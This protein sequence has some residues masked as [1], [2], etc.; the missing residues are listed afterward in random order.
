VSRRWKDCCPT[1][2][3]AGSPEPRRRR[4]PPNRLPCPR[5]VP[6]CRAWGELV[7]AVPPRSAASDRWRAQNSA[8]GPSS[9]PHP[10]AARWG[11]GKGACN[12]LIGHGPTM[13]AIR[14]IIGGSR[15]IYGLYL[16]SLRS[17]TAR[18]VARA[19]LRMAWHRPGLAWP[20][21]TSHDTVLSDAREDHAQRRSAQGR[22]A[23]ARIRTYSAQACRC[24]S[25]TLVRLGYGSHLVFRV[26]PVGSGRVL[27]VARE[28]LRV[29]PGVSG[30]A[31]EHRAQGL[32]A[33]GL[34][35]QRQGAQGRRA[36]ALIRT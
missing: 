31:R 35:A 33:Q 29:A 19:R 11:G 13:S 36:H 10:H 23:R 9:P 2:P 32:R 12:L 26:A 34:R 27:E 15:P 6:G 20:G 7:R 3:P 16:H 28:G 5:K 21:R 24:D 22:R 30:R 1:A 18:P 25:E 8:T 4:S 17:V 14:M